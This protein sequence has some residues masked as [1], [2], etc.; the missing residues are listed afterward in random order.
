MTSTRSPGRSKTVILQN[1]A[2]LSTPACVRES[3]ANT[4]PSFSRT[5]TQKVTAICTPPRVPAPPQPAEL[6]REHAGQW[7]LAM[8]RPSGDAPRAG[9]RLFGPPANPATGSLHRFALEPLH[10]TQHVHV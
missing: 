2:K 3:D 9:R 6:Y 5:P 1:F 7:L 4:R 8:R 10:R